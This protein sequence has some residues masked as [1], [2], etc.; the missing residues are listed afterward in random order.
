MN[1]R[2]GGGAGGRR[3]ARSLRELALSPR[4]LCR[5]RDSQNFLFWTFSLH[6]QHQPVG[7]SFFYLGSRSALLCFRRG[8]DFQ[9]FSTSRFVRRIFPLRNKNG[10][11][12][13]TLRTVIRYDDEKSSRHACPEALAVGIVGIELDRHAP[14][15]TRSLTRSSRSFVRQYVF[16]REPLRFLRLHVDHGAFRADGRQGVARGHDDDGRRGSD[17]AREPSVSD[18]VEQVRDTKNE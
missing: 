8:N 15:Q 10:P 1:S 7:I 16:R 5:S 17:G 14:L 11:G 18:A 9:H 4:Y 3:E 13:Y 12:Y 6:H 2:V